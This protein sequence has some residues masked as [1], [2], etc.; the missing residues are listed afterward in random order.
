MEIKNMIG[1]GLIATGFIV[2]FHDA[3]LPMSVS[4]T[5][6]K[7]LLLTI[8]GTLIVKIPSK[9]IIAL[10]RHV[11][12]QIGRDPAT[13]MLRHLENHKDWYVGFPTFM[14]AVGAV[15]HNEPMMMTWL[16]GLVTFSVMC[17]VAPKLGRLLGNIL[18][19]FRARQRGARGE[20]G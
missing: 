20:K 14:I 13:K 18:G 6:P 10:K 5:L 2:V 4:V 11:V 3:P 15:L 9:S 7:I 12:K 16:Q 8:A 1:Y 19:L 17:I